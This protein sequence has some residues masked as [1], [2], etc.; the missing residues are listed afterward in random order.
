MMYLFEVCNRVNYAI[1]HGQLEEIFLLKYAVFALSFLNKLDTSLDRT[2][3]HHFLLDFEQNQKFYHY[4]LKQIHVERQRGKGDS[5]MSM[6]TFPLNFSTEN[7]YQK[8]LVSLFDACLG[9]NVNLAHE[10]AR[11][12]LLPANVKI[13]LKKVYYL[14]ITLFGTVSLF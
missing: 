8:S 2:F 13:D 10:T 3:Y 6:S 11:F 5:G 7:V 14:E 9:R 1:S 12:N 4:T